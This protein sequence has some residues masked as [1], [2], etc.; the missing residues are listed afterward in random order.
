MG[1]SLW[2]S[3]ELDLAAAAEEIDTERSKPTSKE[4]QL[5]RHKR[6][7]RSYPMFKF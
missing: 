3:I 4:R 1:Y 6:A 2:G 5:C 7:E